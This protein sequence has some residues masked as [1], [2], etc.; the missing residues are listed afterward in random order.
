MRDLE[1]RQF[2]DGIGKELQ[3]RVSVRLATAPVA[4]ALAVKMKRIEAKLHPLRKERDAIRAKAHEIGVEIDSDGDVT[5]RTYNNGAYEGAPEITR[6]RSLRTELGL[7][8]MAKDEK[9]IGALVRQISALLDTK[10]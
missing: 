2:M 4:K 8:R 3:R 5:A 6:F 10:A 1:Y 9:K 7:A